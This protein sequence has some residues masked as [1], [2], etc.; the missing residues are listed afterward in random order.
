MFKCSKIDLVYNI[1]HMTFCWGNT[2]L[3]QK[4]LTGLHKFLFFV[5]AG[6]TAKSSLHTGLSLML[7]IA[8]ASHSSAVKLRPTI[9]LFLWCCFPSQSW[10]LMLGMGG[11]P[12]Q[13][14]SCGCW[15]LMQSLWDICCSYTSSSHLTHDFLWPSNHCAV[16]SDGYNAA[17]FYAWEYKKTLLLTQQHH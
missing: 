2:V 1:N 10:C 8:L 5:W 16:S 3:N 12:R 4:H 14:C 15:F 11:T 17:V 9:S 7:N 6:M 13:C